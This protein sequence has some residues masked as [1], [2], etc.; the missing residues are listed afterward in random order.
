MSACIL[1][2]FTCIIGVD[3]RIYVFDAERGETPLYVI[4]GDVYMLV[5]QGDSHLV[6]VNAQHHLMLSDIQSAASSRVV[7]QRIPIPLD[8]PVLQVACGA[9]NVYALTKNGVIYSYGSNCCGEGGLGSMD[10]NT[11]MQ[12]IKVPAGA[13]MKFSMI[14]AGTSHCLA[15]SVSGEVYAWGRNAEGQLGCPDK[16]SRFTPALM[17]GSIPGQQ[18]VFVEAGGH[19]SMLVARCLFWGSGAIKDP[20]HN[21]KGPFRGGVEKGPP[22]GPPGGLPPP[23]KRTLSRGRPPLPEGTKVPLRGEGSLFACGDNRQGQLGLGTAK[24]VSSLT[25][26]STASPVK[27]VS[28]GGEVTYIVCQDS[29]IWWAGATDS[30]V[31]ANILG[32]FQKIDTSM[33]TASPAQVI[34]G[35]RKTLVVT[36]DRLIH[37]SKLM[38]TGA[39]RGCRHDT[40]DSSVELHPCA[41]MYARVG[42]CIG[43]TRE[44]LLAFAIG[45]HWRLGN[46]S[47]VQALDGFKELVVLISQQSCLYIFAECDAGN[48]TGLHA[49]LGAPTA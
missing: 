31:F 47:A 30:G 29:T 48:F 43:A 36:V 34:C 46:F 27:T 5:A 6:Y 13:N 38:H 41:S 33:L 39:C 28:C 25:P 1:H 42:D 26:I 10:P 17:L 14:A 2:D 11:D 49:L 40:M 9:K 4:E 16:S 23:H 15:A 3:S 24:Y 19:S 45:L 12:R 7:T 44:I 18:C 8:L 21:P 22:S 32:T 37:D 20:A 35:D